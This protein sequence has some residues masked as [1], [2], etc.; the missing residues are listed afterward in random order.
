MLKEQVQQLQEQV[1]LLQAEVEQLRERVDQTS[2]NSSKPPSSDPPEA[3]KYPPRKPSGLRRGG[4]QG[5]VGKGRKLKA[6]SEVDRIEVSKPTQCYG[7][8]T[9]LLGQDPQPQRHQVSELPPIE[10][11]VV[12]YQLHTLTCPAC[13]AAN[14]GEWPAAM[15]SGSFGPRTQATIAYLSGRMGISRRDSKEMLSTLFHLDISLG[16]IPAQERRVSHALNEPV[17]E[18]GDFVR[19]QPSANVDETS[20]YERSDKCW[21]WV[22]GTPLITLFQIMDSRSQACCRQLLGEDFSGVVGSDRYSAYNWLASKQRQLCWS[23]LKRDFQAFE[24]RKGE[25]AVIGKLLSAQVKKFFGLWHQ[26]REGMLS[27]PDF[28]QAMQPIRHD[29]HNLLQIGTFLKT[30]KTRNT[31][32]N[33]LKVEVALWTF[34]DREGI[35]PTNNA[36]ERALRRSV[37]WRRRSFGSQ[38]EAGSRFV[39]RMQTAVITLRQQKRDVLGFLTQACQAAI[40][41]TDP[42]SLLPAT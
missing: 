14:R 5:H 31:C 23:H 39:E 42:P 30:S 33:I 22:A 29:V 4:Q 3:R 21:M 26:V 6:S 41:G 16:S 10:P 1:T 34:V 12:E 2:R 25:S 17:T 35:E 37:I 9:L 36:A 13:G 28:Q 32:R 27:R 24:D 7:C 8:G 20:W 15:P 38:S 19:R 18:A 11:E 40:S